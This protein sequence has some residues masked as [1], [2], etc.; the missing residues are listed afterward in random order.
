MI[1]RASSTPLVG[2]S[3]EVGRPA[4][5]AGRRRLGAAE[6]GRL[7]GPHGPTFVEDE[8]D[9][10]GLE[11]LSEAP[12]RAPF[13]LRGSHS[14]H[15]IRLSEDVHETGSSSHPPFRSESRC[16]FG[17][18]TGVAAAHVLLFLKTSF[19]RSCISFGGFR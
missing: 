4:R 5:A 7:D 3:E 9:G 1:S 17:W 8:P 16:D 13:G 19:G 10:A 11:L 12:P 2:R 14:G 18:T 6:C 15:R